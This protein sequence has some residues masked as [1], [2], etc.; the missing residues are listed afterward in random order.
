MRNR[1]EPGPVEEI[2]FFE[3]R[4]CAATLSV[5]VAVVVLQRSVSC[6]RTI[7]CPIT[8]ASSRS[9]LVIA[10]EG[11]SHDTSWEVTS[12]VNGNRH[13]VGGASLY[14]VNYSVNVV[15]IVNGDVT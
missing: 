12:W 10:P 2:A 4:E 13:R 1:Y 6:E 3:E 5:P 8:P 15:N 14:L 7:L 9:E 11:F